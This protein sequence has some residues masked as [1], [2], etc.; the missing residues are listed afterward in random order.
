MLKMWLLLI[1]S[2]VFEVIGTS[3]LKF[4]DGFTRVAPT[5]GVFILYGL[6]M[7]GLAIVVRKIEVG[8][9]YAVWSG[10]GT[11]LVA[12]IGIAFFGDAASFARFFFVGLIMVGILGLKLVSAN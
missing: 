8:T 4:S 1:V 11:V 2:I 7:W 10:L 6:S 9:A 3:C 5:I 12:L